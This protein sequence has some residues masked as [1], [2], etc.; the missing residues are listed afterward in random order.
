MSQ[1]MDVEEPTGYTTN[2][3][4]FAIL[5]V[6]MGLFTIIII[7]LSGKA[8]LYT[9]IVFGVGLVLVAGL[10]AYRK[11]HRQNGRRTNPP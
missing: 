9:G 10:L 3:L 7:S 11:N 2:E 6:V 4:F 1:S 5:P 8:A